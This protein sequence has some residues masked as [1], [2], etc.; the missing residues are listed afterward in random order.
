MGGE[1]K[2]YAKGSRQG[3]QG[4]G[5]TLHAAVHPP[6][7]RLLDVGHEHQCRGRLERR[8]SAVG[9]VT[10]EQLAQ[11]RIPEVVPERSPQRLERP[12]TQQSAGPLHSKAPNQ[13]RGTGPLR[14]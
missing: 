7:S 13:S 8:R 9:R 6:N 5:Q 12:K 3:Q 2:R 4:L 14:G 11:A 10:G 1:S